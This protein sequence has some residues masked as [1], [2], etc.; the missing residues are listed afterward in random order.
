METQ[1]ENILTILKQE[2]DGIL[3]IR[4]LRSILIKIQ[5]LRG[6]SNL[7]GVLYAN[8]N[9]NDTEV[10]KNKISQLVEEL[11]KGFST[12]DKLLETNP[13]LSNIEEELKKLESNLD[14]FNTN[15]FDLT[16]LHFDRYTKYVRD[17]INLIID[18]A[19]HS[20]LLA[21]SDEHQAIILN[22]IINIVLNLIE[23]ISKLRAIGVS[24]ISKKVK[25]IHDTSELEYYIEIIKDY[26]SAFN[27][28]LDKYSALIDD[29]KEREK[30]FKLKDRLL[31]D[32]EY[33]IKLT[34]DELLNQDIIFIEPKYFFEQGDD[35]INSEALFYEEAFKI[36]DDYITSRISSLSKVVLKEKI[37][38]YT[39]VAGII[40]FIIY[41]SLSLM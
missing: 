17:T 8:S 27:R 26:T 33:F 31:K 2:K 38:Q 22:I 16:V 12:L 34:E 15:I 40:S 37:A 29:N 32:I 18:V 7:F 14:K 9:E 23:T 20:Y 11:N 39:V 6:H 24:I 3:A 1:N 41:E 13:S 36:L 10:Y 21:D 19:D 4:N 25:S 30:F 5:R 35:I 28:E